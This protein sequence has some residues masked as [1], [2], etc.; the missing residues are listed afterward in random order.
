MLYAGY[1]FTVIPG[2]DL[3]I[4]DESDG[5]LTLEKLNWKAGDKFVA[6]EHYNGAAALIR[7]NR[8]PYNPKQL[9]L[10]DGI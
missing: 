1:H 2:G 3:L 7:T 5:E 9:D 8:K 4:F 10:F 6:M